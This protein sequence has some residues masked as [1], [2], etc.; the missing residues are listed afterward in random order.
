MNRLIEVKVCGNYITKDSMY[1][2]VK[3]ESD[4]TTLCITFDDGWDDYGK[5]IVFWDACGENPTEKLLDFNNQTE[6]PRQHKVTIPGDALCRAGD[7]TFCIYGYSGEEGNV[8]KQVSVSAKLEVKDSGDVRA[9]L[10]PKEDIVAQMQKN[11][12]YIKDNIDNAIKARN[13]IENMKVDA[14]TLN[15]GENA[16]VKKTKDEEAVKLLFG[17]PKGDKGET[18]DSGV[19]IGG[20][21][22]TDPDK[23]VWIDPTADEADSFI[24]AMVS[25]KA[26]GAIGDGV[27][28]DTEALKAAA[29][30]G[31]VVYFP[32]GTYLVSEQIYTTKDVNVN[33]V[34]EGDAS[35]I[36]LM[37]VSGNTSILRNE[38]VG[39]SIRIKNMLFDANK[40]ANGSKGIDTTCLY[41]ISPASVYLDNV[42]IE[43]STCDGCYINGTSS[44]KVSINN[45]RF[46]SNGING[47]EGTKGCGLLMTNV[48]G[49][50]ITNCEATT[51]GASGIMLQNCVGSVLSNIVSSNNGWSGVGFHIS[52]KSTL[53]N[54]VCTSNPMGVIITGNTENFSENNTILGL[55]T[56]QNT[57]GIVF[58][59]CDKT[60]IGGWYCSHDSYAFYLEFPNTPK[61]ITGDVNGIINAEEDEYIV[62]QGTDYYRFVVEFRDIG[63][64][65]N[66]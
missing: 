52:S 19:H 14:V 21:A 20:K 60:T 46:T 30:S 7:M 35:I 32:K 3:G 31:E 2:G 13:A 51:N 63:G 29:R 41:L 61:D 66:G 64:D 16:T 10:Q 38:N 59:Y 56:R 6:I 49:A 23:N 26:F 62:S 11:L 15:A 45:S 54:I 4:V 53:M 22:P 50:K 65:I 36:K 42:T 40:D 58:G 47:I 1:A 37:P 8:T 12:G 55:L 57:Y 25:V 17:L 5:R 18:G 44:T 27:A 24:P 39:C 48:T 28:D 9:P 33:W 34:G 43:G